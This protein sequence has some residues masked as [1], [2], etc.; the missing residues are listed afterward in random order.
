MILPEGIT[1]FGKSLATTKITDKEFK[2]FCH[3]FSE[4]LGLDI[5]NVVEIFYTSNYYIGELAKASGKVYIIMNKQYP[6]VAFASEYRN[7]N[8]EF[9]D[10]TY[11]INTFSRCREQF[12]SNDRC[13][14]YRILGLE[15][16][17]MRVNE[18][19]IQNLNQD[20]LKQIKYWKPQV[21]KEI[22]F[23]NWD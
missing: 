22:V 16:L 13:D 23:N 11:Y 12:E 18:E 3:Q 21:L 8:I 19:M 15:D 20:E 9:I 14:I 10:N 4:E 5:V 17:E 6:F 7:G 2:F 1:G